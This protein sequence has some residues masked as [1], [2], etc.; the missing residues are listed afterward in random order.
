MNK[1]YQ[2]HLKS[3]FT[4][5][6]KVPGFVERM[7]RETGFRP[8]LKDRLLLALSEAVTNA[9]VHGNKEQAEK[10]V[11]V[12]VRVEDS[13]V[14]MEVQDEGEGFDPSAIPDPRAKENL[15][16]EGGRG[17]FLIETYADSIDYLDRGRLVRMTFRRK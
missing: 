12:E 17:L 14:Q 10:S 8:D 1:N 16:A 4:E 6:E 3:D 2:L 11:N 9:I 5:V 15:L 13:S 7:S